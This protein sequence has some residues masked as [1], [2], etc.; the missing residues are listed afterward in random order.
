MQQRKY[1][2]QNLHFFKESSI[3]C[4]DMCDQDRKSI[5]RQTGKLLCLHPETLYVWACHAMCF[6]D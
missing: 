1:S 6:R 3:S 5:I 4:V 2:D